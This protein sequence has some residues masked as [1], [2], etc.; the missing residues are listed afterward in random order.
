MASK[1]EALTEYL[2]ERSDPVIE[3]TFTHLDRLIGGLPASARKHQA[4]WANSR[5][6]QPHARYWL[7]AKRRARPDFN[8]GRVRFEIGAETAGGRRSTSAIASR[9]SA[10]SLASTGE[11]VQAAVHFE[12]LAGGAVTLDAAQKPVFPGLPSRPGVYRFRLLAA[13]GSLEGVYIGESD[14]VAR[15][16]GNYRNPGPTQPTNQRLNSRFR[17]VLAHGGAVEL[18]VATAVTVDGE[19]LDMVARPARLLAENAALIRA[20]Q[21]GLPVENL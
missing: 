19:P 17:E 6:A 9:S 11:V 5:T 2:S 13:G 18:A 14:N 3:M 16:M 20:A 7:D 10:A 4:W 1:Y 12:W 21:E 15:R 8:A